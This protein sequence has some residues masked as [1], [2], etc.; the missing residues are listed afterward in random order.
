MAE[1][2]D[3]AELAEDVLFM[4]RKLKESRLALEGQPIVIPDERY[5]IRENPAFKAYEA[6]CRE[7]RQSMR[8]LEQLAGMKPEKPKGQLSSMQKKFRVVN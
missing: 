5:G 1:K 2:K 3:L 4:R 8:D 7:Y 6:L